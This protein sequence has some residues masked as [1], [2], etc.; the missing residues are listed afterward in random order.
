VCSKPLISGGGSQPKPSAPAGR[1]ARPGP[2]HPRRWSLPPWG[3]DGCSQARCVASGT[4]RRARCT[5]TGGATPI[6]S[7]AI[8]D[9]YVPERCLAACY[10]VAMAFYAD[11]AAR[12]YQ[13]NVLPRLARDLYGANVCPRG[14]A[15]FHA[16]TPAGLSGRGLRRRPGARLG[17][18]GEVQ[19][20]GGAPGG[21]VASGFTTRCTGPRRIVQI[22]RGLVVNRLNR[23][24]DRIRPSG[25]GPE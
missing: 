24:Q 7:L 21:A 13:G 20:G 17:N 4:A 9:P 2:T 19:F 12:T 1:I 6:R 25:R 14:A 3:S 15:S 16:R 11:P 8:N 10:G 5:G 22:R 18:R 23:V